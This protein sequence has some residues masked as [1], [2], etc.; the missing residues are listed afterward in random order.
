[1]RILTHSIPSSL[2]YDPLACGKAVDEGKDEIP[3]AEE[4]DSVWLGFG[5]PNKFHKY[6]LNPV[7]N[8]TEKE[9][10]QDHKQRTR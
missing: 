9:D 10:V 6:P 1:M 7:A 8:G 4:M 5:K 3:G 2:S